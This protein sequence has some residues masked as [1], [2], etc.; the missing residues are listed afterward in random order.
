MIELYYVLYGEGDIRIGASLDKLSTVPLR[1]GT[2][3]AVGPGLYHLASDGLGMCIW[4][5]YSEMAHRR[6]VRAAASR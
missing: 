5:L 4:F 6:R 3:L 1:P 2:L